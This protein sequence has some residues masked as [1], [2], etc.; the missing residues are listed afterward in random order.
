MSASLSSAWV[1]TPF[2][3]RTAPVL[4]GVSMIWL[5][6]KG[7][8]WQWVSVTGNRI[9]PEHPNEVS[10]TTWAEANCYYDATVAT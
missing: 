1:M 6:R 10:A 2:R 4:N 8:S 3:Y 9:G 5:Y 7:A